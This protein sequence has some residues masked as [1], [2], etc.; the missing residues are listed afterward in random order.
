MEV[1][2]GPYP[3]DHDEDREVR[4]KIHDYDVWS[5]DHTVAMIVL[6]MLKKLRQNQHGSPHVKDQDV[7]HLPKYQRA[8]NED[9][10]IDMFQSDEQDELFWQQIHDRW[11]WCL[12]EM[13]WA[14]EQLLDEDN[15]EQFWIVKP[16]I[17]FDDAFEDAGDGSGH[18]VLKWQR[19]GEL[20]YEALHRH[21]ERI[22]NGLRLFGTY[23]T[24]L[25]D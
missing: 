21:Q 16:E 1:Y 7:P 20:D 19:R 14:F 23:F 11:K 24:G 4:I 15:E 6:P 13:I 18:K 10:Q 22:Q 3:D 12:D 25:W 8:S 2:I 17:D 5:M 9:L